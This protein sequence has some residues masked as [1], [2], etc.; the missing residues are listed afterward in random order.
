MDEQK[1][2]DILGQDLEVPDI[3]SKKLE[4]TYSHLTEK[5]RPANRKGVRPVRMALIAAALAVG[6]VLCMAAGVPYQMYNF[7]FGG[8]LTQIPGGLA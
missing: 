6:A 1:L 7:L 8:S 3:V 5:Q 2:R 4:N